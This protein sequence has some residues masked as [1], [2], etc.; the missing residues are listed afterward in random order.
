MGTIVVGFDRSEQSLNALR[1]AAEEAALRKAN[2]RVISAWDVP[3]DFDTTDRSVRP[4]DRV[5]Q[6]TTTAVEAAIEQ[7]VSDPLLRESVEM[8]IE[9]GNPTPVLLAQSAEADMIVVGARGTGGFL[10]LILGSTT[11]KLTRHAKCPVVI[12]RSDEAK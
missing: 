3:F 10:G 11:D 9:H 8:I 1:W 6:E 7:V 4:Y 5:R 12:V 2:L